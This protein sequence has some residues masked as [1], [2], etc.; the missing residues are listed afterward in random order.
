MRR[1]RRSTVAPVGGLR[2]DLSAELLNP[3]ESPE[4]RNVIFREDVLR[5]EYGYSSVKTGLTGTVMRIC[6]FND[7]TFAHTED[8]FYVEYS[9][10]WNDKTGGTTPSGGLDDHWSSTHFDDLYI[11]TNGID[12]IQAWDYNTGNTAADLG[13]S[14][15][16]ARWLLPFAGRLCLYDVT[17]VGT[18]FALR[19]RWSVVEDAADWS[20]AGSGS[21]DLTTLDPDDMIM[22]A[23]L[24]AGRPF[25][26]GQRGITYQE[27]RGE[28]S[29]PFAFRDIASSVGLVG[30]RTLANVDGRQHIF[31]AKDGIYRLT[32]DLGIES[33]GE[34]VRDSVF[35]DIT[36]EFADRSFMFYDAGDRVVRLYIPTGGSEL[37]DRGY[38]YKVDDGTWSKLDGD[39]YSAGFHQ[40]TD[41]VTWDDLDIPWDGYDRR[42]DDSS[43]RA[44]ED[45]LY[46]GME[47]EIVRLKESRNLGDA[48]IS[49]EFQTKDFFVEEG[50]YKDRAV[51]WM[52]FA[53][54]ARGDQ[55]DLSYST[56]R[57][58][59]WISV[60]TMS[61]TDSWERVRLDFEV[62]SPQIR[63]KL[64]NSTDAGRMEIREFQLGYIPST[65][66]RARTEHD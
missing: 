14:P 44:L 33:I 62:A 21:V 8:K 23:E 3:R 27:Y 57:G 38:E 53:V 25:I 17:N 36:P 35:G 59:S 56:D 4:L 65:S 37:P 34:T 60:G 39:Y 47:S 31:M 52:E 11:F 45:L 6:R 50:G 10:D 7:Y 9:D 19:V 18:R 13:G 5:K 58:S 66:F 42:W 1:L 55:I 28:F 24:L 54:E 51:N 48:V 43:L 30:R 61:L 12:A 20:G 29:A 63:F 22:R 41:A 64:E 49:S 26:Y 32:A 16:L 46:M 40:L 2:T 15:P